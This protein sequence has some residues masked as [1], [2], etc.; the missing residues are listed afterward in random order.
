MHRV[1]SA[2]LLGFKGNTRGLDQLYWDLCADAHMFC[3]TLLGFM[4]FAQEALPVL[5]GFVEFTSLTGIYM[6]LTGDFTSFS[7]VYGHP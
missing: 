5:L 7:E 1:L 4:E 3:P 2:F 6:G